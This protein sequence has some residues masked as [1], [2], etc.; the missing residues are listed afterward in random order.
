MNAKKEDSHDYERLQED[1]H[2]VESCVPWGTIF[3]CLAKIAQLQD[4][5]DARNCI[6]DVKQHKN[7]LVSRRSCLNGN[8]SQVH[9]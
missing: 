9:S 7:I 8:T 3:I 2:F 4:Q 1:G 5:K 6:L